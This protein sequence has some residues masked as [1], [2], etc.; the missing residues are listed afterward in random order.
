MRA[1]PHDRAIRQAIELCNRA[2]HTPKT[3]AEEARAQIRLAIASLRH[4]MALRAYNMRCF[5]WIYRHERADRQRASVGR[6]ELAAMR[7][8][9]AVELFAR[10]AL[11]STIE[12]KAA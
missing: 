10:A 4:G 12:Q 3:P 2:F 9:R 11:P 5:P 8:R 7:R 6:L 1:A